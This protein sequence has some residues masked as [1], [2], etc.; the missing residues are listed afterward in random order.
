MLIRIISLVILF[1]ISKVTLV[2]TMENNDFIYPKNKPSIFK[3]NITKN[4]VIPQKKPGSNSNATGDIKPFISPKE[5]PIQTSKIKK[6]ESKTTKKTDINKI[7][8][9]LAS[10]N[11]NIFILPKKKPSTYRAVANIQKT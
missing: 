8:K 1:V 9:K 4:K 3:K 7:E 2:S 5:K 6:V 11:K 10:T